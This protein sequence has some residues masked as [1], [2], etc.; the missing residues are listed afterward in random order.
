MAAFETD[1]AGADYQAKRLEILSE[2]AKAFIQVLRAQ[3]T[4]GLSDELLKLS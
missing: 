3:E 4:L 2:A 1:V